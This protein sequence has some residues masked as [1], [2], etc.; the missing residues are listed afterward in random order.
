MIPET[1]LL[2][3]YNYAKRLYTGDGNFEDEWRRIIGLGADFEKVYDEYCKHFLEQIERY[4]GYAWEEHA[5]E[6]ILIYLVG[7]GESF[8]HP[9]TLVVNKDIPTMLADCIYQLT[10]RNMYFGFSSQELCDRC[11]KLV[12]DYVM[13]ET[14]LETS[15]EGKDEWDLEKKTIKEYL[16]GTR[17]K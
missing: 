16:A 6:S 13:K 15:G 17:T 1:K 3:N 10:H 4:T 5:D 12:T 11:L 8:A 9:L 2:Y 7:T 14:N